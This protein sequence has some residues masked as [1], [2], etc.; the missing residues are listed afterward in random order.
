M[1][2]EAPVSFTFVLLH[3]LEVSRLIF[4]GSWL[5]VAVRKLIDIYLKG[6]LILKKCNLEIKYTQITSKFTKTEEN[7]DIYACKVDLFCITVEFCPV[8]W[9]QLILLHK[10]IWCFCIIVTI[11]YYT[12]LI[13]LFSFT[14]TKFQLFFAD[15]ISFRII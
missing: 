13:F 12:L 11:L 15:L 4:P 9:L 5:H 8:K 14:L 1:L 2:L 10:I 6:W 3:L 7:R